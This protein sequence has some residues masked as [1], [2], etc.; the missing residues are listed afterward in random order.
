MSSQKQLYKYRKK[1][2]PSL[3]YVKVRFLEYFDKS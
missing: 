1:R 2:I 3:V